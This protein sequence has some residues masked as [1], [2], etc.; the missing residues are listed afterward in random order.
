MISL[1]DK[2]KHA[3]DYYRVKKN[4]MLPIRHMAPECV[5]TL[6]N[7]KYNP[8]TDIYACGITIWEILTHGKIT[9]F[10]SLNN[11]EVYQKLHTKSIDYEMLLE[12]EDVSEKM[13]PLLV[14]LFNQLKILDFSI[15]DF[16]SF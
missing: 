9:P 12:H 16:M 1:W 4:L 14:S 10:E 8:E 15:T 7:I 2:D 5:S 13:R 6:D 11:D 3:K